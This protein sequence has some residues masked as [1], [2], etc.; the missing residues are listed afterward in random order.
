MNGRL[1]SLWR[2]KGPIGL[3]KSTVS[4]SFPFGKLRVRM[5]ARADNGKSKGNGFVVRLAPEFPPF[6]MRPRRMGHPS[7]C[8]PDL[9]I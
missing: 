5:P 6:A 2:L 8:R 1:R 3:G 7:C 9:R 4:G